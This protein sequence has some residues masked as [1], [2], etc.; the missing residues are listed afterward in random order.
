MSTLRK[1]R[2]ERGCRSSGTCI[3]RDLRAESLREFY[4]ALDERRRRWLETIEQRIADCVAEPLEE[5]LLRACAK[6]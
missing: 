2:A 5:S 6:S 3:E 1:P 4:A